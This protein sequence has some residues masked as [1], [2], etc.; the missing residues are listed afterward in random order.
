MPFSFQW[1]RPSKKKKDS[2]AAL[3]PKRQAWPRN[4][5]P[6]PTAK[7][8]G[9]KHQKRV[10]ELVREYLAKGYRVRTEFFVR[11]TN[12]LKNSRFV[13]VAVFLGSSVKAVLFIQVGKTNADGV[14]PV[15]RERDAA[16]DIGSA[17]PGVPLRFEDY[18]K[19]KGK[20]E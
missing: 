11:I 18:E 6:T 5:R 10:A 4:D 3:S 15:K 20:E 19:E 1:P 9:A 13:D 7:R 17:H 8:G 16:S 2:F 14:T 12:G